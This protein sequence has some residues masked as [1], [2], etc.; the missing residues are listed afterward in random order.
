VQLG[1]EAH[2]GVAAGIYH[3]WGL[4]RECM[5]VVVGGEFR[6]QKEVFPVILHLVDKGL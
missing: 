1:L 4:L 2:A 3:E 5:D 6:K